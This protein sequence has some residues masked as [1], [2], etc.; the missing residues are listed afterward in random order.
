MSNKTNSKKR[1]QQTFFQ[2]NKK[3]IYTGSALVIIIIVIL[4]NGN[5]LFGKGDNE[6]SL[7]SNY[8]G[9]IGNESV[10]APNFNL[11]TIAGKH[12]KLSDYKGKVLIVDFWATWCPPCRRG[13]PDL[14]ELK[15]K[16]GQTGF[17]VIGISVDT[18]TKADVSSFVQRMGINY[19]VVYAEGN[20]TERYGGIESIPTSFVIDKTGKIVSSYQGFNPISVYEDQIKKLLAK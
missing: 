12:L 3:W 8:V 4:M 17:D 20:V 18:D 9:S 2:K 1:Y 11:P 10:T 6:G 7:P 14:I 13:I 15:R 16:Y 19:P 5:S